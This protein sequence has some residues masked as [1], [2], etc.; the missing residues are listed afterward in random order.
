[1]RV[2]EDRAGRQGGRKRIPVGENPGSV[3]G[4]PPTI[5]KVLCLPQQPAKNRPEKKNRAYTCM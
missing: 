2:A 5:T 1:M 3:G 4:H